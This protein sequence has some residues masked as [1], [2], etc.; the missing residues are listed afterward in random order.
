VTKITS[1]FDPLWMFRGPASSLLLPKSRISRLFGASPFVQQ[2]MILNRIVTFQA[3]E[4]FIRCLD[5]GDANEG[6]GHLRA[7]RGR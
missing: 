1:G 3:I 5:G 6:K 4:C 7:I 2:V